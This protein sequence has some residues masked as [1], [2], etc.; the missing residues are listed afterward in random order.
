MKKAMHVVIEARQGAETE[1]VEVVE[2][3]SRVL[4]GEA[5]LF[6]A[7]NWSE[8]VEENDSRRS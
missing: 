7:I 2:D 4:L 1:D 8:K 6:K 3:Q 5:S